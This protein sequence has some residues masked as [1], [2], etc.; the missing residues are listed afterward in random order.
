MANE[1]GIQKLVAR[2]AAMRATA[3]RAVSELPNDERAVFGAA[4]AFRI[5][6]GYAAAAE[7]F[8]RLNA[9]SPL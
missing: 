3:L 2:F 5:G 6:G 9:I 1:A 8:K 7:Q 4:M